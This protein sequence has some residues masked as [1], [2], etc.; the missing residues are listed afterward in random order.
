MTTT[1]EAAAAQCV[2]VVALEGLDH[3]GSIMT[4]TGARA[5]AAAL[6]EARA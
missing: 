2:S 6:R 5:T 3:A 1:S 4:S